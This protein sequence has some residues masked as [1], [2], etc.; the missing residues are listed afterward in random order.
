MKKI[1]GY[2]VIPKEHL[3]HGAYYVG[4]SDQR[5]MPVGVWDAAKNGFVCMDFGAC[6]RKEAMPI[7]TVLQHIQDGRF[8]NVQCFEPVQKIETYL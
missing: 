3:K 1:C 6:Y 2:T 7:P 5:G 4:K 8:D